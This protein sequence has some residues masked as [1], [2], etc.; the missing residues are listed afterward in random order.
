MGRM[1]AIWLALLVACGSGIH[2]LDGEDAGPGGGGG[3]AS[4][5]DAAGLDAGLD[6]APD[7]AVIGPDGCRLDGM[8]ICG[9]G[10][11]DDCD[12]TI[13]EGCPCNP[14]DVQDCFNGKPDQQHVGA[15][16]DGKQ[17]CAAGATTGQWGPCTGGIDPSPEICDGLDNDCNGLVDD[18]LTC[19]NMLACPAPGTLP[20]AQPFEQYTI[21]GTQFFPGAVT[22]WAWTMTGGPCDQLFASESKPTSFVLTGIDQPQLVFQPTQAGDYTVT[23]T[24]SAADGNTYICNFVIHVAGTGLRVELCW[25][26]SGADD[27]DLH[28]HEPGTTTDWFSATDDCNYT[29]CKGSSG[30]RVDWGFAASV[31]DVC[32]NGPEGADWQAIGSCNNPRLDIDNIDIEGRPEDTNI[33]DP[34]DGATFRVMANYYG[35]GGTT[36]P[37]TNIYCQG[38]L[39]ASFGA[40]AD[41]VTGF[42]TAGA[43]GGGSMWRVADITTHVS[44]TSVTTCDIAALHPAGTTTGYDVRNADSTY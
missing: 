7:A 33:D 31:I 32:E 14:G 9:N 18:G 3:D 22:T 11:D 17:T 26:T 10:L 2:H 40:G 15:C 12:G 38:A 28:V 19:T 4:A 30:T 29:N 25:D 16:T 27:I 6:A 43:D 20:D 37:M 44:A 21:D 5:P 36:Q 35:G 13:D 8:D 42:D 41:V 1:R 34:P 39:V 24:I 23:V